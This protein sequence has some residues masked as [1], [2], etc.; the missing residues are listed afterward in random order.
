MENFSLNSMRP[1]DFEE[2]CVELLVSLGFFDVDWR[3]GSNSEYS[4]AD[5]GVD[6]IATYRREDPDGT[7]YDER[8][9]VECKHSS[10]PAIGEEEV[11]K[12]VRA[13]KKRA[14][15]AHVLLFMTSGA[16][17]NAA[18]DYIVTVR[19]HE[20]PLRVLYWERKQLEMLIGR[21]RSDTSRSA[22][23]SNQTSLYLQ[24]IPLLANDDVQ[25]RAG[26]LEMLE[27]V[28]ESSMAMRRTVFSTVCRYLRNDSQRRDVDDA[29]LLAQRIISR[30]ITWPDRKH[31]HESPPAFWEGM[32]IDLQ[33]ALL[34][35]LDLSHAH[36]RSASFK[37]AVFIGDTSL[38]GS[39]IEGD[40][41]FDG[42]QMNSGFYF[43]GSEVHGATSFSGAS[44]RDVSYFGRSAFAHDAYFIDCRFSEHASFVSCDFRGA[45]SFQGSSFVMSADFTSLRV[46]WDATF[47]QAKFKDATFELAE[48]GDAVNF[49]GVR[50]P[51]KDL[52]LGG[53]KV[54]AKLLT[55][56]WPKGWGELPIGDGM[57]SVVWI[58]EGREQE[59]ITRQTKLQMEPVFGEDTQGGAAIEQD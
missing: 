59:F 23:A 28:G 35:N 24:A 13:S 57:V 27:Q 41:S 45:L 56:I 3:K 25:V 53:V 58:P 26:G 29:H 22:P 10:R 16:L 6:I 34:Q 8:W 44:F 49:S 30:H 31:G 40:L 37:N 21:L 19:E 52:N 36:V 33:G 38:Q 15:R 1:V 43:S 42:A 32:E 4:P 9:F 5:G 2:L 46:A 18:K 39:F 55:N 50:A 7:A 20:W 11:D 54:T 17:K 51:K 47:A 14:E 12:L 48:F